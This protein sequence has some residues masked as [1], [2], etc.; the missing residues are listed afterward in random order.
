MVVE[1]KNRDPFGM[2]LGFNRMVF[3]VGAALASLGMLGLIGAG[4]WEMGTGI[5]V[6]IGLSPLPVGCSSRATA[7]LE[8]ATR[9]LEF[10]FLAPL[11]YALMLGVARYVEATTGGGGKANGAEGRGSSRHQRL[12]RA[13]ADLLVVKA[14]SASLFIAVLVAAVLGE[15]LSKNG[16]HY[17]AAICSSLLIAV[18]VCYLA[19]LE[20]ASAEVRTFLAGEGVDSRRH[21]KPEPEGQKDREPVEADDLE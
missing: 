11:G 5:A 19:V 10:F 8:L 15:A 16:V 3:F 17:E 20:K 1:K 6:F 14:F 7:A 4:F 18:I 9:A 12:E 13:R 2:L 21:R